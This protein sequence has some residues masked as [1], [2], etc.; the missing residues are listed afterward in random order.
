[1][2]KRNPLAAVVVAACE[3]AGQF[4]LVGH[5]A[6][7]IRKPPGSSLYAAYAQAS[8][9][10][11]GVGGCATMPVYSKQAAK[12]PMERGTTSAGWL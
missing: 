5:K 4:G 9:A 7:H 8:V 12:S 1:M 11:E 2:R 3:V 10:T 6:L